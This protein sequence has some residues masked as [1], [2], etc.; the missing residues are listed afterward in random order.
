MTTANI[1]A[2]SFSTNRG[3]TTSSSKSAV[4]CIA[5]G[6][7][8]LTMALSPVVFTE[9]APFDL[10]MLCL[11]VL[12][13]IVGLARLT[14]NLLFLQCAW[15]LVAAFGFLASLFATK[16]GQ[17]AM[18]T[19]IT[20]YLSITCVAIAGFVLQNPTRHAR[21]IASGLV[22][23]GVLASIAGTIGYTNLIPGTYDLFTLH[24][25]ARGAFKDPN[26]LGAFLTPTLILA[27][28]MCITHKGRALGFAMNVAAVGI[29]TIGLLLSFS[30]SAW[31]T[32][33]AGMAI[34]MYLCILVAPTNKGRLRLMIL[35]GSSVIVATIALIGALQFGSV[36]SLLAERATLSQIHDIGPEGRFGGQAKAVSLVMNAPLGIGSLEFRPRYHHEEP[37]NVWL[38]MFMNTG[39]IGGVIFSLLTIGTAIYGFHHVTQPSPVQELYIVF[40]AGYISTLM[41]GLVVDTDHWRHF[42]LL[43]GVVW[44]FILAP[45]QSYLGLP[46]DRTRFLRN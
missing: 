12:L 22:V 17:S 20:L 44:G 10:L 27:M 19:A 36:K 7:V 21:I 34:Y 4:H 39:W 2:G 16:T 37:H 32:A 28:H 35:T 9:P 24:G 40:Y 29:I 33:F 8:W 25:R 1:E 6:I 31:L 3:H 26:V 46:A 14:P 5:L 41:G 42:Y 11:I 43:M 30:R 38:A 18:H 15:L 45:P 13:P 23:A